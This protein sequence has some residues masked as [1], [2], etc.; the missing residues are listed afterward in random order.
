MSDDPS[1]PPI[2]AVIKAMLQPFRELMHDHNPPAQK[3]GRRI[4]ETF[5]KPFM[6]PDNEHLQAIGR[7]TTAWSVLERVLGMALSRLAMTPEFPALAL[8]KDLNLDY[9]L[10]ALRTLIALH[11]ERYRIQVIPAE[12]LEILT[13]MIKEFDRLRHRRN[14]IVHTVWIGGA[15]D[16]HSLRS[17]PVTAS[18]SI[19]NP[20]ESL[21]LEDITRAADAIQALADAMF[22]VVQCLPE[23]DEGPH[24]KSLA[25]QAIRLP[26]SEESERPDPDQSSQG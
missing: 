5:L 13:N 15:G 19:A 24:V 2:P 21:S 3:E 22:I 8:T 14:S 6:R 25:Q 11:R 7:V 18:V 16:L 10:K 9:Q 26:Q 17:R 23:V 20:Q 4:E 1:F 12:Y